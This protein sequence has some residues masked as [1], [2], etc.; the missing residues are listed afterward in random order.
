MPKINDLINISRYLPKTNRDIYDATVVDIGYHLLNLKTLAKLLFSICD[1]LDMYL[2]SFNLDRNT[3]F[4][5][6][7]DKDF[8]EAIHKDLLEILNSS[9]DQNISESQL[10]MTAI[11][12]GLIEQT[13]IR[14]GIRTLIL[15]NSSSNASCGV[16]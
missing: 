5:P 13:Y 1:S 12:D 8:L 15:F 3:A 14:F 16:R 11:L 10:V 2:N 9:T 7:I 6:I 4:I